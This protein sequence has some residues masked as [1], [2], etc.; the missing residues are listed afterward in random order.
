MADSTEGGQEAHSS[1][2]VCR[3]WAGL[4]GS[5]DLGDTSIHA[6]LQLEK[7]DINRFTERV[8]TGVSWWK[9]H[10][11]WHVGVLNKC[12]IEERMNRGVNE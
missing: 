5:G 10:R 12:Q 11:P 6:G 3:P 4:W 9:F 7:T 1:S 8:N 2:N